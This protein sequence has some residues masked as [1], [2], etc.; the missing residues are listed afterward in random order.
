METRGEKLDSKTLRC[1]RVH[2]IALLKEC[3]GSG[4]S[5]L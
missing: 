5:E 1:G 4:N 2:D 3:V